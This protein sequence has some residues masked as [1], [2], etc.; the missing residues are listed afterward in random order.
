MCFK[1]FF[2]SIW[3]WIKK[4][5]ELE[6]ARIA[7]ENSS[8]IQR[9][10]EQNARAIILQQLRIVFKKLPEHYNL[11]GDSVVFL[12]AD[13]NGYYFR[14]AKQNINR[15]NSHALCHEIASICNEEL[16]QLR[17]EATEELN[18][19]YYQALY[20]LQDALANPTL[21]NVDVIYKENLARYSIVFQHRCAFL[22]LLKILDLQE[23]DNALML[24]VQ[25]TDDS[26]YWYYHP[27]SV[28]FC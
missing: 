16:R 19:A 9:T 7:E 20:S 12:E 25:I 22:P 27:Q 14:V 17:F 13:A 26:L 28:Q 15:A 4:Q 10:L 24:T 8:C 11:H 18:F 23:R 3:H 5:Q 2:I 6:K 1:D 21:H